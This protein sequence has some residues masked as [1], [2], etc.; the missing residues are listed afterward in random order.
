MK[1]VISY[2]VIYFIVYRLCIALLV[3]KAVKTQ[4]KRIRTANSAAKRTTINQS[5]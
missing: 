5:K 4:G 1:V 3:M 2:L